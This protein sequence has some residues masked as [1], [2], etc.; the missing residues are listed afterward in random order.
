MGSERVPVAAERAGIVAGAID[1][2]GGFG[3]P[4]ERYRER[5]QR[6]G[7]AVPVVQPS[8]VRGTGGGL[9]RKCGDGGD[10]RARL[11]DLGRVGGEAVPH[12]GKTAATLR[13]RVLQFLEPYELER[14]G[15]GARL[16]ELRAD[17]QRAGSAED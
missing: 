11:C 1:F 6:G 4:S 17:Y 5:D 2:D 9:L 8:G 16:R 13:R 3:Y 10:P 15:D 14:S 7:D 12:P